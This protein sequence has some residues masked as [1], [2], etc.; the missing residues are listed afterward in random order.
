MHFIKKASSYAMVGGLGAMLVLGLSGCE[1]KSEEQ[2]ATTG[3]FSEAAKKQGAFVV[4]EE[5]APGKY[6]IVEEYPSSQTRVI[7]RDINGTERILSKEELDRLVAQEAPKI[8]SGQSPLVNPQMNSGGLSLGET[9]LASAAGA[10]IGSWIGSK[11][12]QNPTYQHQRE[13]S[14]KNPSAYRRS[15]NSFK[16]GSAVFAPTKTAPKKTGFFAPKPSVGGST[17]KRSFSF[18]G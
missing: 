6:K 2:T 13:R 4:I 1:K 10:I 9:I 17:T 11:L 8:E 14:F 3:A 7:L 18:G 15:V 12:F 16:K 5:T